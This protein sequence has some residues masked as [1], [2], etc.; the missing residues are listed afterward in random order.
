MFRKN[1]IVVVILAI[2]ALSTLGFV[3]FKS[4]VSRA[5][6]NEGHDHHE[7]E[8]AH[9]ESEKGPKGGRL[10]EDGSLGIEI[11]IF[12][13][14]VEPQ[15]RVYAYDEDKPVP[16]D[17]VS[18][19]I[20]LTRLGGAVDQFNLLP[21]GPYLTSSKIVEEPH[22]FDVAVKASYKGKEYVWKYQS[23]EGRTEINDAALASAGVAV[24]VSGPANLSQRIPVSGRVN[25]NEDKLQRIS[26]RYA[27]VVKELRKR[28][29]ELVQK[30]EVL[31]IIES[32]VS[33]AQYEIR[34][35][36]QGTVLTKDATLG[37][38]V[39]ESD[40]LYTIAD[41]SSVWMDFN[42]YRRDFGKLRLGQKILIKF[43]DDDQTIE[44]AISY[45]SSVGMENTQA[46]IARAEIPNP[47]RDILPGLF[48]HGS[49]IVGNEAVPL[50]VKLSAIQSFRDW[51]VVFV[52]VGNTFEIRPLELGRRDEEWVEVLD[53][54]TAG[55]EYVTKNS[56][57]IKADILKSGASHDH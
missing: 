54:L 25:P 28:R 12:E 4:F 31:A 21:S 49:I 34:S 52:K 44:G 55:Q 13:Q 29:G 37:G 2:F 51:S 5:P 27:G 18:V 42:V 38:Y 45:L 36:Y 11:T 56:F 17:Q 15:F 53:G 40:T 23:Y 14:G 6:A 24:E 35:Q 41:L 8:E 3:L 46:F 26:P 32:N 9:E 48:V 1:K 39:G 20:E 50:A 7:S 43:D 22:S 47:K 30:G 33:L 19:T 57:L 16:S 10:L